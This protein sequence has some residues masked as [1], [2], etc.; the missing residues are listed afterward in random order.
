MS[1]FG[2]WHAFLSFSISLPLYSVEAMGQF[3]AEGVSA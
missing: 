3:G 2:T 1:F